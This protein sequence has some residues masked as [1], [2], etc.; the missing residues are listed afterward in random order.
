MTAPSAQGIVPRISVK[1]DVACF[2]RQQIIT[3]P[4]FSL[5]LPFLPLRMSSL[6]NPLIV[7]FPLMPSRSERHCPPGVVKRIVVVIPG[8]HHS[9]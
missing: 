8:S 2:T 5:S 9:G 7:R 6:A 1:Y 4:P 3:V